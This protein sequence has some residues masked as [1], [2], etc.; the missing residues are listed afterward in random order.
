MSTDSQCKAFFNTMGEQNQIG[1]SE[2]ATMRVILFPDRR[3]LEKR[4]P[5]QCVAKCPNKPTRTVQAVGHLLATKRFNTSCSKQERG[6]ITNESKRIRAAKSKE[7]LTK[8][9][10]RMEV[11]FPCRTTTSCTNR[12]PVDS[13]DSSSSKCCN[14]SSVTKRESTR[15]R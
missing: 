14:G 10:P 9:T 11:T 1:C 7:R 12:F 3:K 8:S 4:E 2:K 6:N 15:H 13:S 5:W